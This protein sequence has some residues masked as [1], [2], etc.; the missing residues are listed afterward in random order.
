M[1]LLIIGMV[2]FFAVHLIPILSLKDS[3]MKKWG[4]I[5]YMGLFSV[6]AGIGLGLMI[7]GKG[8]A[9]FVAIWQPFSGAHWVTTII[10]LP[11]IILIVW[12]HMPSNMKIKLGHPMLMGVSLF[13]V[14][15][16]FANGDLASVL[17]FGSFLIYSLFTIFR[18]TRTQNANTARVNVNLWDGLGVVV[19][20]ALY[21]LAFMYHLQITGLAISLA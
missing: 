7:Y 21:M 4:K 5:P 20:I 10:M 19:G 2:I 1:V 15:H 9:S 18:L 13:S 16:L 17:L 3:L 8:T 6:V 11:A 14:G 12:S